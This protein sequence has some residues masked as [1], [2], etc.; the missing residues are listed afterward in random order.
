[1]YHHGKGNTHLEKR[2]H[3]QPVHIIN[4][5]SYAE[6]IKKNDGKEAQKPKDVEAKK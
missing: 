4:I 1:M 3:L 6:K 2:D 5:K